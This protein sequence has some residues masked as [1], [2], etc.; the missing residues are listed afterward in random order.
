MNDIDIS[1]SRIT[2][3]SESDADLRLLGAIMEKSG[4]KRLNLESNPARA[5]VGILKDPPALVIISYELQGLTAVEFIRKLKTNRKTSQLPVVVISSHAEGRDIVSIL[6]S[7][8]EDYISKSRDAL[9]IKV[10]VNNI[11]KRECLRRSLH[12]KHKQLEEDIRNAARMQENMLTK[13]FPDAGEYSFSCIYHPYHIASGDFYK[14]VPLKE[15]MVLVLL[16]DVSGHGVGATLIACYLDILV[17]EFLDENMI[18]LHDVSRMIQDLLETYDS[19]AERLLSQLTAYIN[20]RLELEYGRMGLFVAAF[21]GIA[22]IRKGELLYITAGSPPPFV[23]Y[24]NIMSAVKSRP[25]PPLGVINGARFHI[26]RVKLDFERLL[27]MTDGIF[28]VA[29]RDTHEMLDME[30][31]AD[32]AQKLLAENRFTLD[33]LYARVATEFRFNFED[34]VSILMLEKK[35]PEAGDAV[36]P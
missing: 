26:E 19:E 17:R 24:G 33:N 7:G 6:E 28:E 3:I 23:Q 15:E 27:I 30:G 11:L 12:K 18:Q 9:E 2:V 35:P 36:K 34:D 14:V 31:L 5:M 21:V 22:D 20:N 1:D 32:V 29:D 25:S 16:A 4:Y 8:A 10:R 13:K